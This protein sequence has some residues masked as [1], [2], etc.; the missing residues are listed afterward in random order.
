MGIARADCILM[1]TISSTVGPAAS[2]I[3]RWTEKIRVESI[4]HTQRDIGGTGVG[5][6]YIYILSKGIDTSSISLS[7]SIIP[8]STTVGNETKCHTI[9]Q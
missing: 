7:I 8:E 1:Y 2:L 6:L 9:R 4:L 3:K 5:P